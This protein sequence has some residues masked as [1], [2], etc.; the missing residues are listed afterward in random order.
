MQRFI[1]LGILISFINIC[2]FAQGNGVSDNE[3]KKIVSGTVVDAE[4]NPVIGA[5]VIES[6]TNAVS[7]DHNGKFTITAMIGSKVEVSMMGYSSEHFVV[8]RKSNYRIVLQEESTWLEET[9]VIGYGT[10]NKRDLT[11]SVSQLN[12]D[13]ILK[14]A[15]MSFDYA[16]AGRVAGVQVVSSDGQPGSLPSITIR[17]GNSLTQTNAPLYI[18]DGF[19]LEDNDN[20]SINPNDIASINILKDASATAIYGAR[21]ANGV[22]IITTK[23]GEAGAPRVTYDGYV[24]IGQ[25]IKQIETLSPYEF[26]KLQIDLNKDS[27][28]SL[29][30][31]NQNK[32]LDDYKSIEGENWMQKVS[33]L[34]I[35]HSHSISVSGGAGKTTYAASF[36]YL[37]QQGLFIKTG[38]DRYQGRINLMQQFGNSLKARLMVNY[39]DINNYGLVAAETEGGST[40]TIMS[41]IWGYRPILTNDD[42][43]DL[44]Q[45]IVD[46]NSTYNSQYSR[47]N[48]YLQLKNAYRNRHSTNL[49][50]NL[51]VDWTIIK[52]L[53]LSVRVGYNNRVF[54]NDSFDNSKTRSGN[55]KFANSKGV[56]GGKQYTHN[57]N[58]SNE[59]TLTYKKRIKKNNLTLL[60]GFTQQQNRTDRYGFKVIN[61]PNESLGM[62]G[63]DE[64]TPYEVTASKTRWT[65][66]SFLGRIDYNYDSRYYLTASF[67]SDGSSKFSSANRWAYFPSC[68]LSWRVT[69]EKF[70]KKV[71][72]IN[73]LKLRTSWG[74]T[75]N[76]RI[77]D[78]AYMSNI[79]INNDS[80]YPFGN[81]LSM[82][83]LIT[84][85]QN[86][87]LKWETTSQFDVG[88]DF[89]MFKSRVEITADYYDKTTRDLLLNADMPT[90]SG[91]VRAY[92]NVGSVRNNGFE[93]SLSTVNIDM[94]NF[95]WFSN[96]NLS[97]N[98][99]EVLGLMDGQ[100]QMTTNI[101]TTGSV[102]NTLY[103][104]TVGGPIAQ[105]YGLK[106]LGT[107]KYEDF[108]IQDDGTW[109]LKP[110][111]PTNGYARKD[112][113]PGDARYED[114]SG[115]GT[116]SNADYQIIGNP[117]P[118]LTGG[119]NN[120][121][122]FYGFD[123]SVFLQFSYGNEIFNANRVL[124]DNGR[125][126]LANTNQYATIADRWSPD[127]PY[128]D[129]PAIN[130][131]G[132][133]YYTSR[134][135]E[136]GSYLNLKNV[137]L[138]YNF[139]T[140]LLKK[141]HIR[142]LRLYLTGSNLFIWTKYSGLT[143]DVSTRTSPM[144]P[145]YDLSPY[146]T[147]RMFS[148]GVK[149]S[150]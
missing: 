50:T 113:Q 37:G 149:L 45:D 13:D 14:T 54:D 122:E 80:Y 31:T 102:N 120:T 148:F 146:P 3:S 112:V 48:P 137:T 128:S 140:D 2:A 138:G 8:D 131:N 68:A 121:F 139:D 119:F 74:M 130:R 81:E 78:F 92:K 100:K 46:P 84:N 87:G 127:N 150:F 4:D 57:S 58:F 55:S 65:L 142:A 86:P 90:S 21:G 38:Q 94:K 30:L 47:V 88:I 101:T 108:D 91:Y 125:Q 118:K 136:D 76:N 66:M 115:D 72:W 56:N 33:Q 104:A 67:R 117:L 11:G 103:I 132:G 77:G 85:L 111:I 36:S 69:G 23:Q 25:Q 20:S 107:Y 105:F 110:E 39:S 12:M 83:S 79:N 144:T 124:F 15:S 70:M 26:V 134:M 24:S 10:S 126:I 35:T 32:V 16:L 7:T 116:I 133:N 97:S 109:L 49:M 123:I 93:F 40:A 22:I 73:N 141:A 43:V 1:F 34:P 60:A 52:D 89:S 41:D 71:P 64:G 135:V 44:S 51:N 5:L 98:F 61:L 75:G 114:I 99:S 82:G 28:T 145:G 42:N 29:Y 106:Y 17:G 143:P 53:T 19:P 18:V 9:V 147:C 6:K 27:A 95:K 62:S 63:L 129:I 96:L 59:N